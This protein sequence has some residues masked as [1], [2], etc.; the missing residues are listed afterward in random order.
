ML[1]S[2]SFDHHRLRFLELKGK[3]AAVVGPMPDNSNAEQALVSDIRTRSHV[4]SY[5][6]TNEGS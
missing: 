4:S 3:S 2:Q 5:E 1:G 6:K